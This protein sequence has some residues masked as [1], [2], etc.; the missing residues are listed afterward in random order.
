MGR[1]QHTHAAAR[2]PPEV[3]HRGVLRQRA[4]LAAG[5]A[6]GA[7]RGVDLGRVERR[8]PHGAVVPHGCV[9]GGAGLTVALPT[10]L[11]WFD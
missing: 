6:G 11:R 4:L 3:G 8:A 7:P 1:T 9:D 10:L 2:R 5:G